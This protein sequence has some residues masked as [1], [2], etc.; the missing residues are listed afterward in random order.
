MKLSAVEAVVRGKNVVLVDDSLV[1]GTTCR[2]IVRMLKEAGAKSVHVRIAS[3]IFKYP[4]FYG[5]DVQTRAELMGNNHTLEEMTDLIEADSLA[6]LSNPALVEA[7]GLRMPNGKPGLTTA[8]FSGH[9]PSPI[10]DYSPEM[11]EA[12]ASGEVTFD[13]EPT[14]LYQ[15]ENPAEDSQ[16]PLVKGAI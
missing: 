6:F 12:A 10:Y 11:A 7:I 4:A 1:R 3:P 14:S 15:P 16:E 2:Y 8:Y 9:Y 13:E 5:I